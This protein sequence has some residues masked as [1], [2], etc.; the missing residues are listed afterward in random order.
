V[1][2][3]PRERQLKPVATALLSVVGL[4]LA[5]ACSNLATL[6]LVR[7]SA[8][9]AEISVR[10]ALGATRW[11]LVRH[12]LME[13][14]ILSFAGTAAGV[15]IA[16]AG[17]RYLATIDLPVILSMQLDYRVLGFATAWRRSA[18]SGLASRL[19]SRRPA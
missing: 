15:A 9:S 1:H 4:V 7:S 11:K 17:L 14:L 2:V 10:L 19:H 8:R 12:L 3:H 18:D 6:L 16:H 13:S 5:I